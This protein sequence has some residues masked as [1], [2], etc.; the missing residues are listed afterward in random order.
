LG[1]VDLLLLVDI[2]PFVDVL[3]LVDGWLL[4][5]VLVVAASEGPEQT[6]RED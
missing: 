5:D 4:V 2:L 3:L 6:E 1:L